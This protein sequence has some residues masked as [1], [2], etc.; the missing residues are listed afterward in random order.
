MVDN[1]KS[2][3][4]GKEHARQGPPLQVLVL[5][6]IALACGAAGLGVRWLSA[7]APEPPAPPPMIEFPVAASTLKPGRVIQESDY[8]TNKIP[9][10]QH[11]ELPC[12]EFYNNGRQ[13]IGRIARQEIPRG[14]PFCLDS[15]YPEGTGP[16]VSDL[17]KP[18]FRAVSVMV[19]LVG[20]VRGFAQPDTWVD[21][22]FRRRDTSSE[23]IPYEARTTTLLR[24]VQVLA[25]KDSVYP[26]STLPKDEHRI[27]DKYEIT[28]AVTPRQAEVLKSLEGRGTISLTLLP[29]EETH[30]PDL[31]VP[32]EETLKSMLGY[33]PP[34]PAVAPLPPPVQVEVY[35]GGSGQRVVVESHVQASGS[36]EAIGGRLP[37]SNKDH[38]VPPSA[39]RGPQPRPAE[40]TTE[41]RS[42][43][44]G[45]DAPVPI[46]G[47]SLG[48]SRGP[49]L[50]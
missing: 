49:G 24:G 42:P 5:A 14:A 30:Q 10:E 36:P 19:E 28:L 31:S 35:R 38:P 37:P 3:T 48:P 13:L 25:V 47:T 17:L 34:P 23:S 8:F 20:G 4:S 26:Q 46:P 44:S 39:I 1:M 43:E 27:Q 22:M 21:V 9:A 6:G 40:V 12:R 18:G 50:R 29:A 41:E 32:D 2:P 16:T 11:S 45:M 33:R 7:S 15:I